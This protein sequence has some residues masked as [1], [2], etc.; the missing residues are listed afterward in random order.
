MVNDGIDKRTSMLRVCGHRR[1]SSAA[2]QSVQREQ[3]ARRTSSAKDVSQRQGQSTSQE[4]PLDG[5]TGRK[6][7]AASETT[8]SLQDLAE[9]SHRQKSANLSLT[10]PDDSSDDDDSDN[11]MNGP[12]KDKAD[13]DITNLTHSMSAL[14]FVPPSV[15]LGKGGRNG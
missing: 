4:V 13:A 15:R 7:H 2:F 3:R 12:I 10:A 8:D 5:E 14:K 1:R 6:R 11:D 9:E